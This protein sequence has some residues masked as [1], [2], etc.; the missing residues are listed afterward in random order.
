M[1]LNR[2]AP[3]KLSTV[4][5]QPSGDDAAPSL[6]HHC[7]LGKKTTLILTL[8]ALLTALSSLLSAREVRKEAAAVHAQLEI[9]SQRLAQRAAMPPI[10]TA[11]A[12]GAPRAAPVQL[13]AATA[14]LRPLPSRRASVPIAAAAAATAAAPVLQ[15]AA[16][17]PRPRPAA[18][19]PPPVIPDTRCTSNSCTRDASIHCTTD[20]DCR[21]AY[22]PTLADRTPFPLFSR[23]PI[24]ELPYCTAHRA[25]CV[26][27]VAERN[28]IERYA[29]RRDAKR[30]SEIF[31][32]N[33]VPQHV[34]DAASPVRVVMHDEWW[35]GQKHILDGVFAHLKE[36]PTP[37]AVV[38]AYRNSGGGFE[39]DHVFLQARVLVCAS[40][41]GS[42]SLSHNT[43]TLCCCATSLL[44]SSPLHSLA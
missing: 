12:A 15:R 6:S 29:V 2:R 41:N 21:S 35:H 16:V 13:S 7:G 36:C 23:T 37:C 24:M 33:A 19:T 44:F 22:L 27:A 43:H 9:I 31:D 26:R 8:I 39:R 38:E 42:L 34:C 20:N 4:A 3:Q 5:A 17:A 11:A 18:A 28:R 10:A 25:D 32:V 30:A 1:K 40:I 14:A